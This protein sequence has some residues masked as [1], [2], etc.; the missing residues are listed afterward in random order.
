MKR[1]FFLL[2][3][4]TIPLVSFFYGLGVG[5]KKWFPF[6][7]LRAFKHKFANGNSADI[8]YPHIFFTKTDFEFS[9]KLEVRIINFN[10][11]R[12][13]E[14][15]FNL[16][17]YNAENEILLKTI[18]IN[19][20]DLI[21]VPREGHVDLI[22]DPCK[23][24]HKIEFEFE[25]T[26]A[27][28]IS[29]KKEPNF[30]V[31]SP[32]TAF[33]CKVEK[34]Q[35]DSI[36]KIGVIYPNF[37]WFSYNSYGGRSLY[38][39]PFPIPNDMGSSV[40]SAHRPQFHNDETKSVF[41][42]AV[43]QK[44]LSKKKI[45]HIPLT[46]SFLDKRDDWQN[47]KLIIITGHD[48]YWT[49]NVYRKLET[50]VK[51][52]GKIAVFSGNTGWRSFH[53]NGL[54]HRR[55]YHWEQIKPTEQLLGLSF[56]YGGV[57]VYVNNDSSEAETIGLPKDSYKNLGGMKILNA[58]HPIFNK[59]GLRDGDYIGV[60][61]KLVWYEIDG[62]PLDPKTDRLNLERKPATSPLYDGSNLNEVNSK[63]P[64]KENLDVLAAAWLQYFNFSEGLQ[65]A[66][67]IVDT[68]IGDGRV[69]HLGSVGWYKSLGQNDKNIIQIF[70][71]VVEELLS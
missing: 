27:Y 35:N 58:Q 29:L 48:E 53:I 10:E 47:L 40:V 18:K 32:N 46:S 55:K 24:L 14:G 45:S 37:T 62:I 64:L 2:S 34:I 1:R 12:S 26:G 44:F 22:G 19:T 70:Y 23:S 7:E 59:T 21:K 39:Q 11:M 67:T 71:N 51:N 33:F 9:E 60:Q 56:R 36:E 28:L 54:E 57:P 16:Y 6:E 63:F 15:Y 61:S 25:Y 66:G 5:Y 17:V 41:S 68:K 49:E 4:I 42:T 31:Q 30:K 52:G 50:Y 8:S 13:T 65:R 38:T 20:S 3:S 43:F 69:I